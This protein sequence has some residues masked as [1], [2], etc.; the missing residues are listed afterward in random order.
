MDVDSTTGREGEVAALVAEFLRASGSFD[1]VEIWPVAPGRDNVFARRGSPRVVL[2]THLDTV[3]PFF[4]SR[5]EATRL[6]GRGACDA[7]GIAAAQIFAALRLAAEGAGDFGLLFVAGEERDSAGALAANARAPQGVCFLIDGEPT[8]GKLIR[9]GKGVLRVKLSAHGRAAHS[10]YPELGESAIDKLLAALARLQELQL[11]HD[12][13]LGPTTLNIGTIAGGRAPNVIADHASAELMFRLVSDGE[14][15][16]AALKAALAGEV[17]H[18]FVLE[19]PTLRL[20]TVEGFET[21][22]VAFGTDIA[23]LGRWGVPLLYGPGSI[24]VAHT[25]GEYI[26]KAEL[27]AAVGVYAALVRRLEGRVP[28]LEG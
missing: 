27:A 28:D 16:R 13:V 11:P 12:D 1:A 23:N 17:E 22:I 15:V 9:A 4:P 19:L 18:E 6:Y 21:G 8:E 26:E 5:E 2:S 7:K 24:H 10:A 14:A 25:E 20:A 3:P